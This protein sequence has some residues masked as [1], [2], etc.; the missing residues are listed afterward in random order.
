MGPVMTNLI[1]ELRTPDV[2]AATP[3]QLID[4]GRVIDHLLDLRLAAGVDPVLTKMVDEYLAAVPGKTV[5]E[6]VWW[7]DVLDR[8]WLT[9]DYQPAV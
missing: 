8:L 9:A 2:V 4:R 7:R 5:V 6:L 1:T 3:G